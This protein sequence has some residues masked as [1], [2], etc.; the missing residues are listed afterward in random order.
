MASQ[1]ACKL[2][3]ELKESMSLE[4]LGTIIGAR[5]SL[6]SN[7]LTVWIQWIFAFFTRIIAKT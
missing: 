7:C 5:E 2:R 3:S 1:N 4:N 6:A